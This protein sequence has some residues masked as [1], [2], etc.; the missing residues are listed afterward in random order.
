MKHTPKTRRGF[1]LVEV[2]LALGVAAVCLVTIFGLLPV[3]LQT[4]RNATQET[5]SSDIVGAVI[6]D[7]R[8]TPV[9][10]PRGGATTTPQ[11]A[12]VIPSNPISAPV[13]SNLFF[14]SEGQNSTSA[15]SNS[16]YRFTITFLPNGPGSRHA[17]PVDLKMTWP[18]TANPR[19]AEGSVEMFAALDRN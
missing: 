12:I 18:A 4:N 7:L 3:G 2:T 16:R 15:T 1:S 10:T 19:D 8:A 13:T 6:A 5:A 11:F 9:T 14:T 17:T